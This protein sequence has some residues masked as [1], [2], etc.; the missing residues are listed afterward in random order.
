MHKKRLEDYIAEVFPMPAEVEDE[1]A[2][3][4]VESSRQ[5]ERTLK[6]DGNTLAAVRGTLSSSLQRRHRNALTIAARGRVHH[7][8]GHLVSAQL[9][10]SASVQSRA[11]KRSIRGETE[12]IFAFRQAGGGYKT[13]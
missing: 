1:R 7:E 8:L 2:R 10:D 5:S 3:K 13:A 12:K 6:P 9:L 11:A 4:W